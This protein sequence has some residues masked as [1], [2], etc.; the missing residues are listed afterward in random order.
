[1]RGGN[2]NTVLLV[3]H[4]GERA[5]AKSSRRTAAA[6]AWLE[7]VQ[8]QAR[9]AGFAVPRFIPSD[10]GELLVDGVTLETW[11]EGTPPSGPDVAPLEDL[12]AGF[13]ALTRSWLQRPGCKST[14]ELV[15]AELGG[16]VDLSVMP[17]ALV[18]VCRSA[19]RAL[20]DEPHSAVHGDINLTNLLV[21][22]AGHI[23]LLDWDEC[24]TDVSALDAV[25]VTGLTG[26]QV[27]QADA[28]FLK[29][30]LAW[31]V[32]VSWR[33]EPRYARRMMRELLAL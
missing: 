13:H 25:A 4:R 2:R 22:P 16:D 1:M 15:D 12:F 10:A 7:P 14:L 32:A 17:P 31:E 29:A 21:T 8:E 24:R 20:A 3:E 27:D 30:S 28:R 9:V 23:A 6:I 18:E 19:W 11:I 5:V 33:M 26:G